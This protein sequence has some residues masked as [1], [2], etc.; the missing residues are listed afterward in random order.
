MN[1]LLTGARGFTG[2]AFIKLAQS[3]G[4]T[5][6]PLEIDLR[7]RTAVYGAILASTQKT[8]IDSVLHL[9]GVSFVAH[10]NPAE[11]SQVHVDGT[12]NL[13]DAIS[14]L[15]Y[16]P[17]RIVLA[18]SAT[19]YDANYCDHTGRALDELS[20][21]LGNG[22]YAQSKLAMEVAARDR[23]SN[24]PLVIARPFNYTGPG[25][26]A[27]FLIPKLVTHFVQRQARI[28]LG[29]LQVEREFNDVLMVCHAYLT[30]LHFG[31]SG[32]TYNICTGQSY[33]LMGVVHLLEE[34]TQHHIEIDINPAFVRAHDPARIVGNPEKLQTLFA[35]H[36]ITWPAMT[37]RSTLERML[38]A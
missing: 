22:P 11:F 35:Q 3:L 1:I 20:P 32:Q 7:D 36:Q 28:A 18:S 2:A 12:L 25:Q 17:E 15:H 6:T 19:V 13:L 21:T 31:Q 27:Q 8:P 24:L 38:A 34:L 30:L 37:L 10:D 26:A 23:F 5:L 9:A 16:K 14:A 4:H 29:N 33:S